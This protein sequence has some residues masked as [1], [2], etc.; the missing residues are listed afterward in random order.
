MKDLKNWVTING[1]AESK[2]NE[3]KYL[4]Q[5]IYYEEKVV[6]HELCTFKSDHEFTTGEIT[7]DVKLSSK[8]TTVQLILGWGMN[9]VYV[10]FNDTPNAYSIKSFQSLNN[11]ITPLVQTGN[12][13]TIK[14]NEKYSIKIVYKANTIRYF[15]NSVEILV[16]NYQLVKA[17]LMF[18]VLGAGEAVISNIKVK[19]NKPKAFVVMQFTEQFNELFE[20]VIK[21]VCE[22]KGLEA[23][24]GDD[25]YSNGLII[26]DI[27]QSIYDSSVI[28]SDITPDNPNVYYEVGYAHAANKAVILMC[29]KSRERLPF[30]LSGFRTIFYTNSI[31]GKERVEQTLEKHLDSLFP[32]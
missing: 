31:S 25:M 19:D 10:C 11:Q 6:N 12:K 20:S 24:R 1:V 3:V 13:S 30:D 27:I 8:E 17:P 26:G 7:F 2:G 21:P 4:P 32:N 28:I 29:D 23:I 5:P 22:A 15:V 14:E 9:P 18:N 16:W